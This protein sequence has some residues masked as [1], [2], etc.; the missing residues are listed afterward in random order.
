[1]TLNTNNTSAN[2]SPTS[3]VIVE[4]HS[5]I[6]DGLRMLL[7]LERK[8]QLVG[9]A[10][11][12]A[13]ARTVIS[14]KQPTIAIIDVGLPDGD[15]IDLAATLIQANPLLRILM[16]TGDLSSATVARALA[17]GAH[18]Y[19]HKQHNADE[20]FAALSALREG[21]RYV[22]QSVAAS[23][24]PKPGTDRAA[25]PLTKLT[26]R[27]REIVGLLCEGDSSKHIARKL[28]LSVATVRK[29]RE[30]I[31]GK[32][33]VHSVAELIALALRAR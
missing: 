14:L 21:G 29:H 20:L 11:T 22:S 6:R 32:L 19:V 30:N 3:I 18:G 9:E 24:V 17:M 1:M 13:D 31:M 8:F 2:E 7:A 10:G 26:E 33:D 16:L 12:V 25:S 15:G 28:D 5:L 4:D 23:Y 27:E